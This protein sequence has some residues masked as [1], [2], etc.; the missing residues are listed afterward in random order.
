V[1]LQYQLPDIIL[2]DLA[3]LTMNHFELLEK[4]CQHVIWHTIPVIV[5]TTA[6]SGML[7]Q[8]RMTKQIKVVYYQENTTYEALLAQIN[9]VVNFTSSTKAQIDSNA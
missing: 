1:Q 4:L 7:A 8:N 3:T 6:A 9:T 5:V 2:I